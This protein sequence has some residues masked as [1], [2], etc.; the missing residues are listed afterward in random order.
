MK[1][2]SFPVFNYYHKLFY[3][4]DSENKKW[5][6]IVPGNIS[7][8]M[9]PVV[10]AFLLMGDGNFDKGRNRIRIYTNSFT[11]LEVRLLSKSINENIKIESSVLLD[12]KDPDNKDKNQYIITIGA[13]QLPKLRSLVLEHIHPSMYYRI[14]LPNATI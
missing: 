11:E 14:G 13:K 4:Y 9:N 5:I 7:T 3:R 1:T 6:K 8:L 12:K 10:L 2:L